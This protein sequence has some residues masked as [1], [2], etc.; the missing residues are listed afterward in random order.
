MTFLENDQG[1][2][3]QVHLGTCLKRHFGTGK[4]QNNSQIVPNFV[5]T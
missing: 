4:E 2:N 1:T 3:Q 5:I